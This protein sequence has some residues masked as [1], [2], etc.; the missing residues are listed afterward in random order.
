M[1]TLISLVVVIS[2]VFFFAMICFCICC[3]A[4]EEEEESGRVSNTNRIDI[5]QHIL[6]KYS[7]GLNQQEPA[8][9]HNLPSRESQYPPQQ[10]NG[11]SWVA[12]RDPQSSEQQYINR[13]NR[14]VGAR[15]THAPPDFG[16]PVNP[17][18]N[19]GV[20]SV[21][22]VLELEKPSSAQGGYRGG[23]T[24]KPIGGNNESER[25]K[26]KAKN[27][28]ELSA[29]ERREDRLNGPLNF[30]RP[31]NP[32]L[33]RGGMNNHS[34]PSAPAVL[35]LENPRSSWGEIHY[36][37]HSH[38]QT[39]EPTELTQ[40]ERREGRLKAPVPSAPAV[41]ELEKPRSSQGGQTCCVCMNQTVEIIFNCGH[42]ATCAE[43]SQS[44]CACP[45]CRSD[46]TSRNRI[47]LSGI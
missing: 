14:T 13:D 46:I 33:D 6:D 42:A 24:G 25:N 12:S 31:A 37:P 15:G 26:N 44:L 34:F 10:W 36:F 27:Q 30:G 23:F 32:I 39:G 5:P 45:I 22:A 35:E 11:R 16:R 38:M 3:C 8:G 21:L 40:Q 4:L 47:Y 18:L 19:K 41:L 17:I 7:G 43:C 2:F 1:G 29:Q 28:E 20:P 9:D